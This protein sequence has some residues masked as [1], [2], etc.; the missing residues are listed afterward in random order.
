[1]ANAPHIGCLTFSVIGHGGRALIGTYDHK[2]NTIS[3]EKIFTAWNYGL[4]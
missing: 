1:M 3:S 2:K 4:L